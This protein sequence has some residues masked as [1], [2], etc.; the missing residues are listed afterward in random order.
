MSFS[1]LLVAGV[2]GPIEDDGGDVSYRLTFGF[3]DGP[4]VVGGR[5]LQ[6]HLPGG[7]ARFARPSTE[8]S[9]QTPFAC[10]PAVS[11]IRSPNSPP[12]TGDVYRRCMA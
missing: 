6:A 3:G 8:M 5:L 7:Q 9:A 4:D 11:L 2:S 1:N 10:D 12:P